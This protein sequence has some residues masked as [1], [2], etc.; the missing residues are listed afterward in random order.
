MDIERTHGCAVVL[1]E[2]GD[3]GQE[4]AFQ[5]GGGGQIGKLLLLLGKTLFVVTNG[6]VHV[7]EIDGDGGIGLQQ[8]DLVRVRWLKDNMMIGNQSKQPLVIS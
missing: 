3:V 8:G 1:G 4:V 2:T 7:V 5:K 6:L